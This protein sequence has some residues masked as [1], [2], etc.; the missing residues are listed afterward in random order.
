MCWTP[1]VLTVIPVCNQW[2][3]AYSSFSR[4]FCFFCF[5]VFLKK[6]LDLLNHAFVTLRQVQDY[7][8]SSSLQSIWL[9]T[10]KSQPEN[11][12]E[13]LRSLVWCQGI[14]TVC[15]FSA[16]TCERKCVYLPSLWLW[17]DVYTTL[18]ALFYFTGQ[19]WSHYSEPCVSDYPGTDYREASSSCR[20]LAPWLL[21]CGQKLDIHQCKS[22]HRPCLLPTSVT[23]PLHP[24]TRLIYCLILSPNLNK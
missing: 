16:L 8:H 15:G 4:C 11:K 9:D 18:T 7:S 21:W 14:L 3:A 5:F 1:T 2:P 19:H 10:L 22:L 12:T 17:A 13:K 23:K 24:P 6:A 20:L